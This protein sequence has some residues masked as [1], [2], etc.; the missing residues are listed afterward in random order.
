M[1]ENFWYS[2]IWYTEWKQNDIRVTPPFYKV[3]GQPKFS[4]ACVSLW[5]LQIFRDKIQE[6][7]QGDTNG[8]SLVSLN[9]EA[10]L[11]TLEISSGHLFDLSLLTVKTSE[12]TLKSQK[13]LS[14][15][16]LK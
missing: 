4:N 16:V 15:R 3:P 11:D 10:Q 1:Q 6:N 14:A 5:N 12:F 9:W 2:K 7:P 8:D 13:T